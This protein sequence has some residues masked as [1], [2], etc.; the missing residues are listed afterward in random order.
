[1][2]IR[3]LLLLLVTIILTGCSSDYVD[4][5][6]NNPKL[7]ISKYSF[8]KEGETI[9]VYSK[10]D[11]CLYLS[12]TREVA[13]NTGDEPIIYRKGANNRGPIERIDG[14]W[15]EVSIDNES[16]NVEINVAENTTEDKR[17]LPITIGSANYTVQTNYI[18]R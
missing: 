7:N 16:K 2:K 18:Q 8:N 4:G 13:N 12:F 14:G 3:N 15:Y 10:K 11:F 1:M 6:G 5:I 17:I 9:E